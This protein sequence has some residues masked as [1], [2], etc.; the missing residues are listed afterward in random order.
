MLHFFYFMSDLISSFLN[1]RSTLTF[2]YDNPASIMNTT[3]F[4]NIDS[5]TQISFHLSFDVWKLST[6]FIFLL[7]RVMQ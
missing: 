2:Q 6:D 3:F 1:R 5:F 7:T 4:V